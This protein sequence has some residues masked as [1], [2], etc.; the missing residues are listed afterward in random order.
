VEFSYICNVFVIDFT[1]IL[2]QVVHLA[3]MRKTG[4]IIPAVSQ[5]GML[6][7]NVLISSPKPS[8][9]YFEEII[10]LLDKEIQESEKGSSRKPNNIVIVTFNFPYE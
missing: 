2:L 3:M 5:A 6:I 10:I 1:H 8:H 9:S 7:R 4:S